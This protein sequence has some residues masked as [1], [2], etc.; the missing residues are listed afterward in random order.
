M[1]LCYCI[2]FINGIK[3][4]MLLWNLPCYPEN[5]VGTLLSGF[6]ILPPSPEQNILSQPHVPVI[7]DTK[8][9]LPMWITWL[10]QSKCSKNHSINIMINITS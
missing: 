1:H 3:F 4:N 6:M 2:F 8:V 10:A 9:I 7:S 5:V